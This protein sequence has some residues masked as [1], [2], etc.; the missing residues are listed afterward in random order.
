M[1][2]QLW[3]EED[4]SVGEVLHA[5]LGHRALFSFLILRI[6]LSIKCVGAYFFKQVLKWAL[7]CNFHNLRAYLIKFPKIQLAIKNLGK[8]NKK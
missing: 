4:E 3:R 8:F 1:E 6:I 2:G 5:N 7:F